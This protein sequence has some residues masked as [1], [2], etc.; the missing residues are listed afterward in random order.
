MEDDE[1]TVDDEDAVDPDDGPISIEDLCA[2][3]TASGST[4]DTL[5]MHF[6][7]ACHTLALVAKDAEKAHEDGPHKKV[8]RGAW[9]KGQYLWNK[10]SRSQLSAGNIVIFIQLTY[11]I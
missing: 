10:Q 6:R 1:D 5:P 8:I 3:A 4:T 7:C 9:A 2:E 11:L